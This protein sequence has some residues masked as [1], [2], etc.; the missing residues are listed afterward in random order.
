MSHRLAWT[1]ATAAGAVVLFLF[2]LREDSVFG[3]QSDGASL[4]L[5]AWQMLHGNLLLHGWYLAD[6]S[7][8]TT[9][10]PEYM[11][12]E[13]FRGIS[14]DVVQIGTA[15]TYTL[16]VL[17]AAYTAH[18]GAG[19]RVGVT[20]VAI[21]VAIMLGPSLGAASTLLNDPDHTGT[22][23]PV[24]VVFAL[25]DRARRRWYVP[26]A[27]G[28]VLA[29]ALVGDPLVLLIGV[30]PVLVV[31]GARS[32][33]L[34]LTR[35]VPLSAAW[36]EL[37]LAA[38]AVLA[39]GAASVVT[40]HIRASGGFVVASKHQVF[41][42]PGAMPHNVWLSVDNFLA[43]FSANFFGHRY[44]NGLA[45]TAIHLVAAVLVVAGIW[46][47]LRRLLSGDL[48]VPLLATAIVVN[49]LAY[50][51]IF[52]ASGS[53]LREISPVFALGA[54]LA[55]RVIAGP[56]V[57]NRLELLLVAGLAAAV[58]TMSPGVLLVKAAKPANQALASW[59]DS[60]HLYQGIA[61]Y[62][63]ANSVSVDSG[64]AVTMRPV[65][66]YWNNGVSPYPWELDVPLDNSQQY[67]VNFLVATLP[68]A[69]QTGVTQRQA[70][71]KFGKPYRTYR[72][73][74]Y[75]IMVWH[76]NLLP[77]LTHRRGS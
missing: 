63:Q 16:L 58:W 24:L 50:A 35:R 40:H 30:V 28:L 8:Y 51:V 37:S 18:G 36:Y 41:V 72:F 19:G 77:E 3:T 34:L 67:D 52:D 10:L 32:C 70:I 38:A 39:V 26:V 9:V 76:K 71:A 44:G 14:P 17:L 20:R 55:G 43:L 2:A 61:G 4:V 1:A 54:A 15:L 73:E 45:F 46:L 11:L 31:C 12:V 64:G 47:G 66:A 53:T 29:V 42:L 56:L 60:H 6:V 33:R 27:A 65:H 23:V 5:Q 68:G 57:R 69:R 59:L 48:V 22:A 25:I 49:V 7:F 75:A 21:A 62:W 74:Q 13:I